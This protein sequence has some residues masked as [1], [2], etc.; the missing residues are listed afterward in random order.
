M[1]KIKEYYN[2]GKVKYMVSY[3]T[4]KKHDDGSDFYDIALF[5]NKQKKQD[6]ITELNLKHN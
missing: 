4:G 3:Y 6:F 2:V 1:L 5:S